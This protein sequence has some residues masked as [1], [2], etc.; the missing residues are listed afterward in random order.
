MQPNRPLKIQTVF[1]K[2]QLYFQKTFKISSH[3]QQFSTRIGGRFKKLYFSCYFLVRPRKSVHPNRP[4]KIR[5]VF[6]SGSTI[7]IGD[8]WENSAHR[9]MTEILLGSA[10][11]GSCPVLSN[12]CTFGLANQQYGSYA[13]DT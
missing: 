3:F 10:G 7:G 2:H 4:L 11:V 5:T 13:P 8:L 12:R 1:W 6:R 9:K